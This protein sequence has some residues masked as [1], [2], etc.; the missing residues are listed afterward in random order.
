LW[1]HVDCSDVS[2][3]PVRLYRGRETDP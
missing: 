2:T 3:R 1:M